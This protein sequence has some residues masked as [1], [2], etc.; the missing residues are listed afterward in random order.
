MWSYRAGIHKQG[1]IKKQMNQKITNNHNDMRDKNDVK[2]HTNSNARTF[3]KLRAFIA[4]LTPA[5]VFKYTFLTS[6]VAVFAATIIWHTAT[7]TLHVNIN[8]VE[9]ATV[10]LSGSQD[11]GGIEAGGYLP[12]SY[13]IKNQSTKPSY[14]F[15]RIQMATPGLYEVVDN[16]GWSRVT[17]ADDSELVYAYTGAE[18]GADN[19]SAV[20]VGDNVLF[21]GRLHCLASAEVYSELN[22]SDMDIEVTGCLIYGVGENGENVG[23]DTGSESLWEKFLE[24]RD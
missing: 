3:E 10:V 5:A 2:T 22:G 13:S 4:G 21:Q 24:N 16:E 18:G 1:V 12:L 20:P 17:S 6:L 7:D 15:I 8:R 11:L 9:T 19:M 14:I 23:Y